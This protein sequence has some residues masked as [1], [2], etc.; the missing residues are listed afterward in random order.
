MVDAFAPASGPVLTSPHE[1]LIVR[2]DVHGTKVTRDFDSARMYV[3]VARSCERLADTMDHVQWHI[4]EGHSCW[5]DG[6]CCV[7]DPYGMF[8]H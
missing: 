8:D 1:Y 3:D 5:V 2:C 7:V 6:A 4:G